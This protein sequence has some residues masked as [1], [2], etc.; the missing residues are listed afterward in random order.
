MPDKPRSAAI[1]HVIDPG[2]SL[3]DTLS[4]VESRGELIDVWK[5]GWGT[6]YLEPRLAEKVALLREHDIVPCLGGTL[7]EVAYAQQA[8]E[9]CLAWALRS[10]FTAVEVSRG[11]VPMSVGSKQS[12][13]ERA[14][15]DFTV[16]AE[17]GFKDTDR[18]LTLEEWTSEIAGDLAA[19]ASFAVAEGR[20]SGTVGLYDSSGRPLVDVVEA[21]VAAAGL[22]RAIFEAPTKAQQVWFINR[23]GP[24]VNLGN[25]ASADV[26]G[27]A[28]LRRGLRSDTLGLSVLELMAA[29]T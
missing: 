6:A 24:G 19:G 10:G 1:T 15:R 4:K 11:T 23:F 28:T 12:L 14:G 17:T 18:S 3:R 26:L 7:L 20:E 8:V 21:V 29:G 2:L 25:V 16:L 5:F 22:D 9:E 27:L 13:I